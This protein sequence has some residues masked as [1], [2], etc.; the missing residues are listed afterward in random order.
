MLV[1]FVWVLII[2]ALGMLTY[3]VVGYCFDVK[4]FYQYVKDSNHETQK[5]QGQDELSYSVNA[6]TEQERPGENFVET[7]VPNQRK[8]GKRQ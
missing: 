2:G 6:R 1:I 7:R 4:D 5:F 8:H 3:S